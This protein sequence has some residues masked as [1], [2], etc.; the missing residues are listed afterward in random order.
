MTKKAWAKLIAMV[1]V[2]IL[3]L[4]IFLQNLDETANV[5][6]FIWHLE[7]PSFVAFIVTFA[8][9]VVA[10]IITAGYIARGKR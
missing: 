8:L 1:V 6:I 9:G 10:G 2:I 5:R 7:I 4:I 3:L